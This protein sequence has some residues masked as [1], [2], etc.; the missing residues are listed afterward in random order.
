MGY[1]DLDK[2]QA[3]TGATDKPRSGMNWPE[4]HH[5]MVSEYQQSG[6]PFAVTHSVGSESNAR[7][8]TINLPYVSQWVAIRVVSSAVATTASAA[9]KVKIG[10]G[11]ASSTKGVQGENYVDEDFVN[12]VGVMR[13]KTKQIKVWVHA[14][15]ND[16]VI[17]VLAGLTNV[18]DFPSMDAA[19]IVGIT[20][21]SAV[22]ASASVYGTPAIIT[23]VDAS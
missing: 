14:D 9:T 17:S 15:I 10:F 5:G 2:R 6:I 20:Q 13:L 3:G 18:R 22:S 23:E 1:L 7:M 11:D 16:C 21:E 12:A 19:N 8:V 4:P